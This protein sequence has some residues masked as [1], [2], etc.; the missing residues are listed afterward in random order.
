MENLSFINCTGSYGGSY[1]FIAEAGQTY[2][3]EASL[4]PGQFGTLQVNLEQIPPPAN[5]DFANATLISSLPF[6]EDTNTTSATVEANEPSTCGYA[7]SMDTV[8]YS[9]T[10]A[11]TGSVTVQTPQFSF[12]PAITVFTGSSL[13]N[14]TQVACES[15][16]YIKSFI[17]ESNTTYY[18]Q[19]G[20]QYPWQTGG[21][22]HIQL[23]VTPPPVAGM[24]YYPSNPSSY[25]IVQFLD[26]SNDPGNTAFQSFSWDFGDGTTSTEIHATHQYA[27]DGDYTVEHS[28]TTV[29][30]R[31]DSISQVVQVRTHDVAITRLAAPISASVGQTRQITVSVNNKRYDETVLVEL[32]KSTPN[33]YQFVGSYTQFVP[34]RPSNRST[35]FTFNYTFTSSDASIGKVT[36]RAIA[37]VVNTYDA[38]PIDNELISSPPT[39]INR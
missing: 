19:V 16:T 26:Q 13:E 7:G 17:A 21:P 5:D 25:S 3:F 14:L 9:F 32:Y 11:A 12:S 30:G 4:F 15:S 35:N 23:D 34:V 29:D 39:K 33:G 1:D 36:F 6:D 2:Y 28:V 38:F 31:T 22:I 24:Y 8:W 10:P 20:R 27:A 37:I 18:I